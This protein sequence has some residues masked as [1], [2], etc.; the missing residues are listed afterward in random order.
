MVPPT[1]F[2][3]DLEG[4]RGVA[5]LLVVLFH[6]GVAGFAG[7]FIGVDLFFVLSGFF[8]TGALVR[9]VAARGRIDLND[10]WGRRM[11]RL[12]PPLLLVLLATLAIVMTLYAPIDRAEA[13]G[14]GRYVSVYA[15]NIDL[16]S[17]ARDY[18]SSNGDPLLHTWSLGVEE[19]FYILWPLLLL[20]PAFLAARSRPAMIMT[21]VIAGIASLVACVTLTE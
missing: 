21:I 20:V 2:R 19:Q 15:G 9:E 17:R 13:A 4:L 7:G 6:A 8:I 14:F 12:S 3:A 16:A 11:L 1:R 5:I 18:F 10:F